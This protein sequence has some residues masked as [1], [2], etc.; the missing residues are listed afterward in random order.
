MKQVHQHVNDDSIV[1]MELL[2][3]H[4]S[5]TFYYEKL[6]QKLRNDRKLQ[7]FSMNFES[8]QIFTTN[9]QGQKFKNPCDVK[10]SYECQCILISEFSNS[11]IHVFDL[12]S[13]QYRMAITTPGMPMYLAIEENYDKCHHDALYFD[14]NSS[15]IVYKYH[16]RALL[17]GD[18]QNSLLWESLPLENPRAIA[19]YN[20][21]FGDTNSEFKNVYVCN[22]GKQA[23]SILSSDSGQIIQNI[24]LYIRSPYGIT[25]MSENEIVVS[26]FTENSLQVWRRESALNWKAIAT[27][28][29][30]GSEVEISKIRFPQGVAFDQ[31]SKNIILC[32]NG[33]SRILIYS[34]NGTLVRQYNF[35]ST[36]YCPDGLCVN[37][38]TGELI[39]CDYNE[40]IVQ[41]FK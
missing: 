38:K 8:V 14:C 31:V 5:N 35:P 33:N 21:K 40:C 34:Q 29:N 11:K 13:R 17:E 28:D 23:V 1:I 9:D 32:D 26:D 3:L 22:Y 19:L 41:I 10:I 15:K 12:Y 16:L 37:N 7:A 27:I 6:K 25:C 24:E 30:S 39:V 36:F 20:S 4:S 18:E 2:D